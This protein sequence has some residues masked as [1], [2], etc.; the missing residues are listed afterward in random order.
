MT[1]FLCFKSKSKHF[2]HLGFL[3]LL[4]MFS[5]GANAQITVSGIVSD[6]FGPIPGVNVSLK[7]AKNGV[8]TN[9]DGKYSINNVS[10]N[11]VIVYSFVGFVTQE[12]AVKGQSQINIKLVE[13]SS[14]LKEV[15]VIGYGT[16]RNSD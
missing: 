9:I 7:G 8:S 14:T 13:E 15:V 5:V 1:N 2:K 11:A 4:F 16:Q 3:L 12:V 6:S 10:A